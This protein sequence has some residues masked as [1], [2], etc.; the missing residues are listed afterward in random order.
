M[1]EVDDA[2]LASTARRGATMAS[3]NRVARFE[4]LCCVGAGAEGEDCH[5]EARANGRTPRTVGAVG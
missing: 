5:S 3:D 4:N 2:V 1:G